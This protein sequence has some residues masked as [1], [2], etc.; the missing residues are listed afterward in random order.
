MVHVNDIAKLKIIFLQGTI[1]NYNSILTAAHC[2]INKKSKLS[3]IKVLIGIFNIASH[4]KKYVYSVRKYTM[5]EKYRNNI[6]G[7]Y[8]IAILKLKS[9][10]K[11]ETIISP[12]CW[13]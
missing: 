3:R 9:K 11:E 10:S 4:K 12:S 1:L 6:Y 2:L 8:D 5:H 13:E 7:K